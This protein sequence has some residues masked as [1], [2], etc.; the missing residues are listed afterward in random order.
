MSLTLQLEAAMVTIATD[1]KDLRNR[2]G[3][4]GT[5]STTNKTNTVAAINELYTSLNSTTQALNNL[6]ND[7]LGAGDLTHTWS[8]NQ[9]ITYV[10]NIRSDILGG[11]PPSTLDS[12][13]ELADGIQQNGSSLNLITT[14]LGYR[15]RVDAAQNFSVGEQA[16]GRANIGAAADSE[17]QALITALGNDP[18]FATTIT[19]LIGT[20]LSFAVILSLTAQEK[21]NVK[22]SIDLDQVNNTT[23]LNKP[24]S[25]ATI[26]ALALKLNTP[27]GNG[28]VEH[29]GTGN[30]V[31]RSLLGTALQ[32]KLTQLGN[33]NYQW[34]LEDNP[35]IPGT[36]YVILPAGPTSSRGAAITGKLKYNTDLGMWEGVRNGIWA[37]LGRIIQCLTGPIPVQTGA[38]QKFYDNLAPDYAAGFVIATIVIT[39]IFAD[40]IIIVSFPLMIDHSV[41]NRTIVTTTFYSYGMVTGVLA[42]STATNASTAGRPASQSVQ[43][44]FPSQGAG[45]PITIEIKT[46]ANGSGTTY[47][48]RGSTAT[49]GNTGATYYQV[50]E[51]SQ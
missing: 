35:T 8:I 10:Q 36:A 31:A 25:T 4:L 24:L 50:L 3:V 42:G 48:N 13:Y 26:N 2:I 5:L 41:N 30:T 20:K 47:I 14:S 11:I 21:L 17:L 43:S 33:G 23:D 1:I 51:V 6:I 38:A 49:M 40:S 18:N 29:T 32:V 9:I 19:N 27:V 28:I 16:Q 7:A 34:G 44:A 15:V 39:P 12:I 22:T 37:P 45:V 46:G